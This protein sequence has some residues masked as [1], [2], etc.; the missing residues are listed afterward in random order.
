MKKQKATERTKPLSV[1]FR[2][3]STVWGF[4]LCPRLWHQYHDELILEEVRGLNMWLLLMATSSMC[5]YQ[6]LYG[7]KRSF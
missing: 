3:K 5:L 6:F 1:L 7:N 4:A 2:I